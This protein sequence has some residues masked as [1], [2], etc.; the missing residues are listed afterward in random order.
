MFDCGMSMDSLGEGHGDG[1]RYSRAGDGIG[2]SEHVQILSFRTGAV[3]A[4]E[5]DWLELRRWLQAA[6]GTSWC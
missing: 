6:N 1:A 5:T 4:N 3:R 2:T